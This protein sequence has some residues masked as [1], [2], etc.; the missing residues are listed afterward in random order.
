MPQVELSLVVEEGS[1]DVGLDYVGSFAAVA[2]SCSLFD[3]AFDVA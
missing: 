3:H 1:L 2:P